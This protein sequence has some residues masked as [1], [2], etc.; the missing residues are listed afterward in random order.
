MH[1]RS[2][3]QDD[4][5]ITNP[6]LDE[7][8]MGVNLPVGSNEQFSSPGMRMGETFQWDSIPLSMPSIAKRRRKRDE[9]PLPPDHVTGKSPHVV[10]YT[11]SLL[12]FFFFFLFFSK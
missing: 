7:A 6:E 11:V 10:H 1:K 2:V 8:F 3:T 5:F 9:T 4:F 12:P